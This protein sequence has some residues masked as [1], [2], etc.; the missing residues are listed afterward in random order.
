MES[1]IIDKEMLPELIASRIHSEKIKISEENDNIVL[2]PIKEKPDI[3]KEKPNL[4]EV[5]GI[6]RGSGLSTEKFIAQ[7]SIEIE[8][9]YPEDFFKLFGAIKDDTFIEPDDIDP[10][11]NR[12]QEQL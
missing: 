7:K 12:T 9:D 8:M 5:F 1:V 4:D 3:K 10:M 6:L 2:S 11:Y